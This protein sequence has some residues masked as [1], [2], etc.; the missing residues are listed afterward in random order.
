MLSRFPKSDYAARAQYYL[1]ECRFQRGEFAQAA[2]AYDDLI[3][4]H[5]Q[6]ELVADAL[7]A[8]GTAREELKQGDAAR[9]AYEQLTKRF[10]QNPLVTEVRMRQAE[11][12]FADAKFAEAEPLFA[13]IRGKQEFA[14]ADLAAMRQARC[15]YEAGKLN[16][17]AAL[18][19]DLT[20]A[21]PES[22]HIPAAVL[23]GAKCFFLT[24]QYAKAR[25]GLQRISTLAVPEAA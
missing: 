4:K 1:G 21:F 9:T 14:L 7:Y 10:P 11:L 24:G 2:A 6:D 19:W 20:R 23:A 25:S 22:K 16:E 15:V 13:S 12:L 3:A 8:L 5:P 18:Y 17:A